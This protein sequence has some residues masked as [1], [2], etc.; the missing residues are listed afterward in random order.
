MAQ[1]NGKGIYK[2]F[3]CDVNGEINMK[4]MDM[5]FS[6]YNSRYKLSIFIKYETE[7]YGLINQVYV[8]GSVVAFHTFYSLGHKP[9]SKLR[10]PEGWPIRC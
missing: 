9:I 4:V 8:A 3:T 1:N 2:C 10:W 6:T 7:V 5:M